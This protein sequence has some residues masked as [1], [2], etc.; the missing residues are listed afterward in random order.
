MFFRFEDVLKFCGWNFA[1]IFATCKLLFIRKKAHAFEWQIESLFWAKEFLYLLTFAWIILRRCC[2][3]V[4]LCS[5]CKLT[6]SACPF[7]CV[8]RGNTFPEPFHFI[9]SE[10]SV[11]NV[12]RFNALKH[13]K[14]NAIHVFRFLYKDLCHTLYNDFY[15]ACQL[16][17]PFTPAYFC[18]FLINGGGSSC[19]QSKI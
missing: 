2:E 5:C 16:K 3:I 7:C 1:T 19:T 9:F 15:L 8:F 11:H 6:S 10:N 17:Y 13:F 14:A 18:F 4:Q 12:F